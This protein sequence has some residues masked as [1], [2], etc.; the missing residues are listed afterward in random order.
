MCRCIGIETSGQENDTTRLRALLDCSQVVREIG[1]D[2]SAQNGTRRASRDVCE[3]ASPGGELSDII[4]EAKEAHGVGIEPR[5]AQTLDQFERST[6]IAEDI[7]HSDHAGH[8][9][10][11]MPVPSTLNEPNRLVILIN[12]AERIADYFETVE[13]TGRIIALHEQRFRLLTDTGQV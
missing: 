5:D 2:R 3:W 10:D 7:Q 4:C 9:A 12:L 13:V 8:T 1:L 6:L 11:C